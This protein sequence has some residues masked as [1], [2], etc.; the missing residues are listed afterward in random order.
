MPVAEQGVPVGQQ[1][2]AVPVAAR[3]LGKSPDTIR[4]A[5]R[6][7]KLSTTKG[8]DGEWRVWLPA[9]SPPEAGELPDSHRQELDNLRAELVE[10][11][12]RATDSATMVA[13][14]RERVA[15][16]GGEATVIAELKAQ[17]AWHR[18]P[19]WRR[20]IG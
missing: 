1:G 14:L 20:L 3:R 13:K 18:T 2:E 19:W 5:I 10:T 4:S 7:G 8:N 9:E 12:R 11:M 16:L 6:R 15:R 17:L